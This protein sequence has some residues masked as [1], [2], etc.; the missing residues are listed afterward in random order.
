MGI[1]YMDAQIP[2][3]VQT[4]IKSDDA[5][6][7]PNPFSSGITLQAGKSKIELVQ[8]YNLNGSLLKTILPNQQTIRF[9]DDLETGMYLVKV[10]GEKSMMTFKIIKK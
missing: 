4:P 8:V 9:G 10:S 2:T 1:P 3:A 7:F 6:L 5:V